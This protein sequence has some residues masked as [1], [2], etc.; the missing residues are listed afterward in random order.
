[1]PPG[2]LDESNS[3]MIANLGVRCFNEAVVIVKRPGCDTL[4]GN[5][6]KVVRKDDVRAATIP[7]AR[8]G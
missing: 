4:V 6:S 1:M 3:L 5:M 8:G 7:R 2:K